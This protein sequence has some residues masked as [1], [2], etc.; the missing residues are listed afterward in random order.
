MEF[1]LFCGGYIPASMSASDPQAEHTRLM[2]EVDLCVVGDQHN[3]KYAWLTEHHFL[4]E[5]SHISANEVLMPHILARTE[6][7]P[8]RLRASSTSRRR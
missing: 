7:D 3:W 1:G 2:S 8:H 6:N 5:Y 4:R